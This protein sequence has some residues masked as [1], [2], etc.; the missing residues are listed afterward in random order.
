M[1]VAYEY[2]ISDLGQ[3]MGAVVVEGVGRLYK[4]PVMFYY[5]IVG[6]VGILTQFLPAVP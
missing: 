2:S 1:K 6:V 3:K 5:V 4:S